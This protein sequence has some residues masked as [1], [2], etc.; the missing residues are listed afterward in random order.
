MVQVGH[1]RIIEQYCCRVSKRIP[2]GGKRK[3]E[4]IDSLK[5]D[6]AAYLR[7][8]PN[9]DAGNVSERFGE[10]ADI[11]LSFL[12]EMSYEEVADRFR[13]GKTVLFITCLTALVMILGLSTALW[14]MVLENR[15]LADGHFNAV[16][17]MQYN[18][19]ND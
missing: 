2:I 10:P 18:L 11:A 7:N 15:G 9:A 13:K 3:R 16:T 17:D 12:S 6:V 14:R 1:N 4:F 5:Q 19:N 8:S